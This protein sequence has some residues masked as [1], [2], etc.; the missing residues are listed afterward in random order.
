MI[1]ENMWPK[2]CIEMG[3]MRIE[4][5]PMYDFAPRPYGKGC[6]IFFEQIWIRWQIVVIRV[7]TG[8]SV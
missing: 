3:L 4:I 7:S 2:F 6:K 8:D 1:I 5:E